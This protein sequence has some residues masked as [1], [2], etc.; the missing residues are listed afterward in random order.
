MRLQLEKLWG[1]IRIIFDH[2]VHYRLLSVTI[3]GAAV[4]LSALIIV[5]GPESDPILRQEKAWPVSIQVATPGDLMPT[6]FAYGRVESRQLANLKTSISAP[7]ASVDAP[8][9]TWVKA[10][11]VLVRLDDSELK[12]S[13]AVA[14]AEYKKRVAQLESAKTDFE[15]AQKIT[16]HHRALTDIAQAKLKRHLDLYAKKMI[17]DSILDEARQQAS[18]RSITL[19]RHLADI[20]IFPNIIDQHEASVAEG[21][22]LA[23]RAELDLAQTVIKAPF[24]GRVISTHVA[25]GD[26]VLPGTPV[27]Q[28]ADYDE[29]EVRASIPATT[30]YDLR[31][32]FSQGVAV[33]ATGKLDGRSIDFY[34]VRLS[35]D[36][37]SGQSGLDAFFKTPSNENL[38]IGRVVNLNITL[39]QEHNVVALPVQSL[40]E[41]NRVYKVEDDRLKGINV[42]QV[43]DYIDPQ[44]NYQVL[45]RSNG[46]VP[47]DRLITTQLPRAI[48]GLLVDPI[49]A[50]RFNEAFAAEAVQGKAGSGAETN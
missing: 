21:R 39:P 16:Q 37:K 23:D 17:S 20:K 31:Q 35:G 9:G 8:E 44:G 46:I 48:T 10:G 19:E 30:G 7:V 40:Y 5:T 12:L 15:L 33:N 49:D 41:N 3:L 47:G 45:I 2:I 42:Q 11:D 14:T 34:L 18:E 43:G 27:I 13:L 36:V 6:L 32:K 26:R 22:A 4:L 24:E 1:R 28:V 38:D 29:L 50:A 25:P